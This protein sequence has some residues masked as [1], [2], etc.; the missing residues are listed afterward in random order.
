MAFKGLRGGPG[1]RGPRGSTVGGDGLRGVL[2][3]LKR[4]K[5]AH[6]QK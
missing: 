1:E 4:K 6:T 5:K 3:E 2:L